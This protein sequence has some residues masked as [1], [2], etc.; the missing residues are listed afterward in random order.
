M[1]KIAGR[2]DASFCCSIQ[3]SSTHP[4]YHRNEDASLDPHHVFQRRAKQSFQQHGSSMGQSP[5]CYTPQRTTAS[6]VSAA[7]TLLV[8]AAKHVQPQNLFPP[9]KSWKGTV[10]RHLNADSGMWHFTVLQ[11]L[12]EECDSRMSLGIA[13]GVH[14]G[15]RACSSAQGLACSKDK[16]LLLPAPA[17]A[18]LIFL[19]L[20]RQVVSR[21]EERDS[22]SKTSTA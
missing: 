12:L 3:T 5:P 7:S 1:R 4:P 21:L 18:N 13:A 20:Y 22:H 15:K 17:Q 11:K 9:A 8:A 16:G 14:L 10:Q 19:R 6:W 2:G